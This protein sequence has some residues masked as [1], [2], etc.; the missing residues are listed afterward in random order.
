MDELSFLQKLAKAEARLPEN[1]GIGD[2]R[3]MVWNRLN[4]GCSCHVIDME[5][6]GRLD[7]WM[8]YVDI[9]AGIG[10]A[11]GAGVAYHCLDAIISDIYWSGSLYDVRLFF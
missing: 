5:R 1:T 4:S 7:R 10:I 2:I 3:S 9:A 8:T 6:A 11:L